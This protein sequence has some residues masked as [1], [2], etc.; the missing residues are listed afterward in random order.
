MLYSE[1]HGRHKRNQ[2]LEEFS[3]EDSD[4]EAY[5]IKNIQSNLSK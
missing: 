3:S 4:I 5:R 1:I 2:T